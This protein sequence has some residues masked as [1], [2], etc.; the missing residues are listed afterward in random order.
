[1]VI[2]QAV[3]AVVAIM[4]RVGNNQAMQV[5][6]VMGLDTVV[7][8]VILNRK[9]LCADGALYRWFQQGRSDRHVFG[10]IVALPAGCYQ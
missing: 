9:G 10:E 3:Q 4:V 2:P 6:E 7:S 5:I 1:M 8:P